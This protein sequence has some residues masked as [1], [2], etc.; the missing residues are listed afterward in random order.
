MC[1]LC[2]TVYSWGLLQIE[3]YPPTPTP[4]KC[5]PLQSPSSDL[6]IVTAAFQITVSLKYMAIHLFIAI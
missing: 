5:T 6:E 3:M 1:R 2:A 4:T